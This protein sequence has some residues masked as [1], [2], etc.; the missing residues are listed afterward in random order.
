LSY[1]RWSDLPV[2]TVFNNS[3]FL[4]IGGG[5]GALIVGIIIF[6]K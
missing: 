5:I 4:L 1:Q 3:N 6:G 2:T